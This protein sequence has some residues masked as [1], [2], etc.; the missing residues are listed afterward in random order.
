[1]QVSFLALAGSIFLVASES[2][3]SDW[4]D[5]SD[6]DPCSVS[7]GRGVQYKTRNCTKGIVGS[8]TCSGLSWEAQSCI[9]QPCGTNVT[10]TTPPTTTTVSTTIRMKW[11]VRDC[12]HENR[13]SSYRG[14]TIKTRSGRLCQMW[15]KTYPHM[16]S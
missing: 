15:T 6:W 3:R 7:C 11:Y 13:V 1:M 12:Y 16:H 10:T 2:P 5:W 8:G 4:T 9:L 14:S